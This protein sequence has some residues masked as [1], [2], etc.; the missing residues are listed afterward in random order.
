MLFL[1]KGED[2]PMR[3]PGNNREEAKQFDDHMLD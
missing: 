2:P 3:G 1:L